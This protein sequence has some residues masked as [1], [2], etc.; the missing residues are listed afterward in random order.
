[1]KDIILGVARH[2]LTTAGG[3][4]TAKGL[5]TGATVDQGVGAVVTLLGIIWS[6]LEKLRS[7]PAPPQV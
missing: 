3:A 6:I 2:T 4:L 1:M 7:R 5:A